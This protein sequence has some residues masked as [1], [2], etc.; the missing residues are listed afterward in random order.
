M[1]ALT[2]M[3]RVVGRLENLRRAPGPQGELKKVPRP[4]GFYV[5][6]RENHEGYFVFPLSKLSL[7]IS[8]LLAWIAAN[9]RVPR[10]DEGSFRRRAPG[11]AKE[12]D[13][14]LLLFM[15]IPFNAH[16]PLIWLPVA[17][18]R[19]CFG[20]HISSAS[21]GI[22]NSDMGV[23]VVKAPRAAS[24][25]SISL[26]IIISINSSHNSSTSLSFMRCFTA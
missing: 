26:D 10:S 13:N 16:R 19:S 15:R 22:S 3:L 23:R 7:S 17:T 12:I 4:G 14:D 5:Y 2:S 20:S 24:C 9:G 6:M 18:P 21:G 1:V 25:I 11:A 8:T